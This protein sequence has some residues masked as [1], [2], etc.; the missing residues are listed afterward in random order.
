M[1]EQSKSH[2]C[3]SWQVVLLLK[4]LKEDQEAATKVEAAEPQPMTQQKPERL[5][6]PL[7]SL[8]IT[9]PLTVSAVQEEDDYDAVE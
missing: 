1:N 7:L 5:T 2:S 8:G 4:E 6:S 9:N 3:S